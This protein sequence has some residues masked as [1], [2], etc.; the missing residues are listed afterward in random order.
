MKNYM[1][2]LGNSFTEIITADDI[3]EAAKKATK[4]SEK[5]EIFVQQIIRL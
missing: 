5:Y 2:I 4:L 3:L 1:I